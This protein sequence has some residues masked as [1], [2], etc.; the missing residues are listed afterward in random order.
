MALTALA[1]NKRR[2]RSYC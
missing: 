1:L 2:T